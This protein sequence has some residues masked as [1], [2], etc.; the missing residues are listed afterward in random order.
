MMTRQTTVAGSDPLRRQTRKV[1]SLALMTGS[2]AE[3]INEVLAIIQSNRDV[4]GLLA[5][6]DEKMNAHLAEI[7]AAVDRGSAVINRL[8]AYSREHVVSSNPADLNVIIHESE[9]ELRSQLNDGITLN[10]ELGSGPNVTIIDK[11]QFELIIFSL[12]ENAVDAMGDSGTI[13][14]SISSVVLDDEFVGAH[15]GATK[16]KFVKVEITD[17]GTGMSPDIVGRA[18][19]PFFTTKEDGV[20]NGLGLSTAY[21]F[22]KQFYGYFDLASEMGKGTTVRIYLPHYSG[23]NGT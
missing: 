21:S 16:G 11:H 3:G 10:I 7:E 5:E 9:E 15:K 13:A 23:E 12:V 22:T 14:V 2:V 19:E 17:D 1:E 6:D 8:L 18:T 4:L 20:G